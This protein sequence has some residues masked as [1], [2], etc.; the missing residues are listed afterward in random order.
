MNSDV[1]IYTYLVCQ[2]CSTLLYLLEMMAYHLRKFC[3]CTLA[4][5]PPSWRSVVNFSDYY[6]NI[7]GGASHHI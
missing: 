7:G 3:Q 1:C 5:F 4:G 2:Y 6:K